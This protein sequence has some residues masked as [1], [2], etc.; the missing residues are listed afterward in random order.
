LPEAREEEHD[1]QVEVEATSSNVRMG[2]Y[3]AREGGLVNLAPANDV[4]VRWQIPQ[5]GPMLERGAV[6]AG[7]R[8]VDASGLSVDASSGLFRALDVTG[9]AEDRWLPIVATELASRW[10]LLGASQSLPRMD[11]TSSESGGALGS[12]RGAGYLRH[13]PWALPVIVLAAGATAARRQRSRLHGS[14]KRRRIEPYWCDRFFA[15]VADAE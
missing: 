3:D 1:D 5:D 11:G 12:S 14:R 10:S 8:L 7:I 2:R 15:T 13:L 9:P 6:Q 4:R